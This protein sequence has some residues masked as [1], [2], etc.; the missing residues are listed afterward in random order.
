MRPLMALAGKDLRI[1]PRVR[2]AFFFTFV[3]PV[4]VA[5]MFGYAF[6]GPPADQP[7]AIPVA[8][9]DADGTD[10]SRAFV[11]RLQASGHFA[12]TAMTRN[13]AEDAVRGGRH[14]A[15]FVL[16]KGFG[17]RS[18]RLFYGPPREIEVGSD[19]SRKAEA[20][21]LEGL[22]MKAAAEDMQRVMQDPA[23][24]NAVV[25]EALA[26]LRGTSAGP[27]LT[28][29]LTALSSFLSSPESR[30]GAGGSAQSGWQPLA[31]VAAPI[32]RQRRGP[33]NSFAVTFPQGI[34]WALIGCAMSFGLSLVSER[35]RGTFVRL[36]M[37]PLARWQILAGKA[38]ACA[39][40][41]GAVQVMLLAL[42]ATVFGVRPSSWAILGLACAAATFA[43]C[44]IMMLI[45]TLGQTEQAASGTAWALL[46][47]LS[48]IGG[49]MV[50]TFVMPAWMVTAGMV[51][52]IR[53][54]I[55]ALEGGLWRDFSIAEML[56]PCLV[57]A[58][59]GIVCFAAGAYRL[60]RE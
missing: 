3:W 17:D 12:F 57:L 53:W 15:F 4:V 34:L 29:F 9:V 41:M 52:P 32:A 6:G 7:R 55:L 38:L 45:A 22:L 40:A 37:S 28:G 54:A 25:T 49:G 2:M 43:F 16:R 24:S 18:R 5:V 33:A 30:R 20:G 36:Q 23:A 31:I 50:P 21:M 56:V 39:V 60:G 46:M 13:E 42:A 1:L 14:A 19:P 59:T 26:G 11:S 10:L 35:T 58:A 51:S 8:L 48:L 44:G 47:P 27:E